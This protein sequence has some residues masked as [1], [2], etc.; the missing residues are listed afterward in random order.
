MEHSP[1][2]TL[3]VSDMDGTLLGNDSHLSQATTVILND[4]MDRLG[5]Q[6]TVAT[7]RTIATVVP[8]MSGVHCTLPYIVLSGAALWNSQ[9]ACF[10]QVCGIEPTLVRRVCDICERHGAH[11]FVYRRHGNIIHTHHNGPMEEV[12]HAFVESRRHTPYKRYFLND[13][14]YHTSDDEAM[15]IFA[16]QHGQSLAKIHREISQTTPCSTFL[17]HDSVDPGLELLEVYAP[18]CSKARAVQRLAQRVQASR[19]VVFGDN[20]NDLPMFDVA[21]YSVAV[22]NAVAEVRARADEV[23]G[24]NSDDAV[25]EWLVRQPFV[26]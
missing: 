23:I 14:D 8:L 1:H 20:L 10:E 22:A 19:V 26:S 25:A 12:E 2:T 11:P 18:G 16:M 21:D 9:K 13:P 15:L 7:S 6:F 24:A 4:L 5:M 3:Y 17:Y